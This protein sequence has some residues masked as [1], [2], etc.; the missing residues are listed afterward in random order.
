MADDIEHKDEELE[1][2]TPEN[3]ESESSSTE[4]TPEEEIDY[5]ALAEAEKERAEAERA[6]AEAAEAL[7]IKNKQI[8]KRHERKQEEDEQPAGLTREEVLELIKSTRSEEE[9]PEAKA[10]REAQ[11]KVKQLEAQRAEAIRAAKAK[12]RRGGTGEQ[13]DGDQPVKPKLAEGS[14]L[15]DFEW[16]GGN[17]YAKK[18][19]SGKVMFRRL[20][21]RP[22]EKHSWIE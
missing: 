20:N 13:R 1:V 3:T 16:R 18:L 4:D 17:L 2:E 6:R 22:G 11:E 8:E 12:V 7:I 21:P 15:K 19:A 9:S 5:K 14:P 10:L